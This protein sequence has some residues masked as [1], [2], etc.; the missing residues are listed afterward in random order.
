MNRMYR[1]IA[2]VDRAIGRLTDHVSSIL[3]LTIVLVVLYNVL[4]RYVFDAPPFWSDRIS[5]FAN[6]GMILF[7]LSLT[8]RG[9]E[10]IAMQAL[11]EKIS[12]AFAMSLDAL[13]NAIILAFSI[14][15]AWYGGEVAL[16]MPGQY[17]DFQDMCFD[18]GLDE[19]RSENIVFLVFKSVEGLVGLAVKPFCVDGAVPQR[20]LAM[21]IPI[22]G[23]LLVIAT[24]GVLIE[25]AKKIL[26]LRKGRSVPS[27]SSTGDSE[28]T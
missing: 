3:L 22:S 16:N 20:Y 2:N 14:I 1:A 8:I 25:D 18:M 6:I 23:V 15:F 7:G 4:M 28:P 26:A 24:T 27:G 17:W 11:Y 5:V 19:Q 21:L 13:W 12:P 10:L 9:R